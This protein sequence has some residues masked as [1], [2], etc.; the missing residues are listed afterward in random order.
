MP[1]PKG[2]KSGQLDG[3]DPA[4]LVRFKKAA[5]EYGKDT[6]REA[7]LAR[8]VKEGIATKNGRLTKNYGG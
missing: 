6:S 2:L 8:L 7:S 1:T 4:L 5:A 3:N